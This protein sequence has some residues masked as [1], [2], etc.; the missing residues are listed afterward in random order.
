MAPGALGGCLRNTQSLGAWEPQAWGVKE[1]TGTKQLAHP[2]SGRDALNGGETEASRA[3]R[4]P[5]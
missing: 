5:D 2:S 1:V 3:A 4:A